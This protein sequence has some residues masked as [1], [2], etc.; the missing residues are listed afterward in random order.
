MNWT[1]SWIFPVFLCVWLQPSKQIF[2]FSPIIWLGIIETYNTIC[3]RQGTSPTHT[4]GIPPLTCSRHHH[5]LFLC[6]GLIVHL[7]GNKHH[8]IL[9]A[10]FIPLQQEA[11]TEEILYPFPLKNS[12]PRI[13]EGVQQA[14]R[15][16][17]SKG[18]RSGTEGHQGR[19]PQVPSN[20]QNWENKDLAPR[21]TSPHLEYH[22]SC[23]FD[24]LI[25][26]IIGHTV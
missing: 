8:L 4:L 20:G 16:E 15:H 5:N 26:H 24:P 1:G 9:K 13:L 6:L 7:T 17:Q 23:G 18:H 2:H 10:N 11:A 21:V 3:L 25:F 19:K 22:C 14:V 12:E